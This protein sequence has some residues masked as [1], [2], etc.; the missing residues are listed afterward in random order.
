MSTRL[1][2]LPSLPKW[3]KN[4]FNLLIVII[5]SILIH[6]W[7]IWQ[8]PVDF[9][10]PVY[11]HA[12]S[13]YAQLI[14]NG[15]LSGIIN[16]QE[17]REH[18]PLTKILYSLPFLISQKSLDSINFTIAARTISAIFGVIAVA[19][20]AK[21]NI[22]AGLF[23]CFHSMTIKYTSQAYLEALPMLMVIISV[24]SL[25]KPFS[26][27]KK[28]FWISSISL[29]VAVAAKYPYLLI[30]IVLVAMLIINKNFNIK[31]ILGYFFI[32][33]CVF[34]LLNPNFWIDP[35]H[36]F[37]E[38]VKYHTAYSQSTQVTSVGYPWYQ[39]ILHISRSVQ[40]HPQV[41]FFLTSDELV[42]GLALF[43]FYFELKEKKFTA[44][45]FIVGIIFLLIWPTKWPQYTLFVTPVMA[46][47]AGTSVSR[48]INW[49]KPKEDYWNY[50]EEML[51]QPPRITWWVLGIFVSSLVVGKIG[52]EFQLALSR[53][54]WDIF[55]QN[56]SPL[57]SDLVF[58]IS[59]KNPGE[60]AFATDKGL[61]IIKY[62]SDLNLLDDNPQ[63][64]TTENSNLNTNKITNIE[65]DSKEKFYWL[66]TDLGVSKL[67]NEFTNYST[68]EIGCID[69][70]VNDM[71]VDSNSNLWISTNDG[72]YMFDHINW[73]KFLDKHQG[74]ED[75]R[76]M[77]IFLQEENAQKILWAG[78]LSGISKFDFSMNEWVNENW[79]GKYFGWGGVSEIDLLSDGRIAVSTLGGG[80]FF[81][82]GVD[83]NYF[84]N[85]NSPLKSNSVQTIQEDKDHNL[86]FG[87][88]YPT[89]PGGYLMK[90]GSNSKWSRYFNN[91]SGY[92]EGEPLD[93]QF[94]YQ[95]RMWVS[96]NGMGVQTY[97]LEKK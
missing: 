49:L 51:P 3:W 54:G 90:Y 68:S 97:F 50:L 35:I 6:V 17:N 45:W 7:S 80:I 60:I 44:I 31:D 38:V 94:D 52:F 20:V 34:L 8:L 30:I 61:N 32:S 85:T 29:G 59:T 11:V 28:Y 58:Q 14:S 71:Y 55:T 37:I 62:H 40:W 75:S 69:C 15:D 36:Q 70:Q 22:W 88:G 83:W 2:N 74:I 86:W 39:Q 64:Y 41:F 56:N 87:M 23:L 12:G 96:T 43:G 19:L 33:F 67:I 26:G 48:A 47:I 81:W 93:I 16:L 63:S 27:K 65:Y 91:N 10:E 92:K 25:E 89:E 42:F 82:N 73:L 18:P 9:D 46:L 76:V 79:A 78:T 53:Q 57:T 77:S 66:G 72:I 84:R 4:D 13:T 5:F 24:L 21:R 95:G 1:L